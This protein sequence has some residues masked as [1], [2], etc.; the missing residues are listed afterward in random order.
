MIILGIALL[1]LALL[2]YSYYK[3]NS[4]RPVPSDG[5]KLKNTQP[6]AGAETPHPT[7]PYPTASPSTKPAPSSGA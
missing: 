2:L 7:L 6:E 5:I 4:P 3:D 1:V